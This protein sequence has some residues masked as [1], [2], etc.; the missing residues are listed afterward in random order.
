M[1]KPALG[2]ICTPQGTPTERI[3]FPILRKNFNLVLF[4][5][6][7]DIDFGTL[8]KQ[9]EDIR[10]V[11]NTAADMPNTYDSLEMIKTFEGMGK[12]VIDSSESFYYKEDK[13]MF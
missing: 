4:P 6:Q 11:L 12:R 3:L 1:E 2:V 13:W 9:A 10:V 5:I 8:K 7:K